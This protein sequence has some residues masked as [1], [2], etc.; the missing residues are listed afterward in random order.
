[1]ELPTHVTLQAH[2]YVDGEPVSHV[3]ATVQARSTTRRTELERK[4]KSIFH[5][6]HKIKFEQRPNVNQA[7]LQ[8]CRYD[9]LEG[10]GIILTVHVMP[11]T[12]R[13]HLL[14]VEFLAP[15]LAVDARVSGAA[16]PPP[17]PPPPRDDGD[18]DFDTDVEMAA[19]LGT[20]LALARDYAFD[21]RDPDQAAA[22]HMA[23]QLALEH[24]AAGAPNEH[25]Y[26]LG[27]EALDRLRRAA[28]AIEA[29]YHAMHPTD[30]GDIT[31]PAPAARDG[32]IEAAAQVAIAAL[33]GTA[34]TGATWR[35]ARR[36]RCATRCARSLRA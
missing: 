3:S 21:P 9:D 33:Y 24:A 17:P 32:T 25:S 4:F 2:L 13:M 20:G 22:L 10:N 5:G 7:D 30:D 12:N 11:N 1:M 36:S 18:Y 31:T 35:A 26:D 29:H 27:R 28:P 19:K 15:A 34:A 23:V 14:D 16:R 6:Q 8:V